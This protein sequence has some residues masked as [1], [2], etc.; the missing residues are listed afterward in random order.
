[1]V[2]VSAHIPDDRY[3]FLKRNAF[4][5]QDADQFRDDK[6]RMCVVDLYCSVIREIMQVGSLCGA[7]VDHQLCCVG[8]HEV[9]LINAQDPAFLITVIR[10]EEQRQILRDL[11]LVEM[12]GIRDQ[13]FVD[14]VGI[15]QPESAAFAVIS[16]NGDLIHRAAQLHAFV[17][18]VVVCVRSL[19]P[20]FSTPLR[21]SE[22]LPEQ[23]AVIR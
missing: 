21:V 3:R 11:L 2:R 22:R 17:A 9:F 15:K 12:D 19:H 1:M 10:I 23:S 18:D 8:Y 7:F 14:A 4:F 16:G 20:A 5:R 13:P 6:C